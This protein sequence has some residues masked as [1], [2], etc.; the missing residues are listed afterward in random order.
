MEGV[1]H[2]VNPSGLQVQLQFSQVPAG[3]FLLELKPGK[4]RA[5]NMTDVP[6]PTS[7]LL[8]RKGQSEMTQE[9][10]S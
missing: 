8:P 10:V 3:C 5:C 1:I 2:S 9:V 7:A 6:R 4:N